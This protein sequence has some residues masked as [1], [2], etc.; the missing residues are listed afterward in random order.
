MEVLRVVALEHSS[1]GLVGKSVT[2]MPVLESSLLHSNRGRELGQQLPSVLLLLL[3]LLLLGLT[4]PAVETGVTMNFFFLLPVSL[5]V[6]LALLSV[7]FPMA[8]PPEG[9]WP[10]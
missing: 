10:P 7:L 6:P 5:A 9:V 4:V 8:G 2:S 1:I 3:L